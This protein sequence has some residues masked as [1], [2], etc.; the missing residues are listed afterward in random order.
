[1]TEQGF[2]DGVLAEPGDGLQAA[3][4]SDPGPAA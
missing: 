2:F 3:S 1:M 4:D